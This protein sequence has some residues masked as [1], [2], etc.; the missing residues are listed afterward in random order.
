MVTRCKRHVFI[1]SLGWLL[2]S[3]SAA[4]QVSTFD[5]S[6]AVADGSGAL[7]PGATVTL[8]NTQTG[9]S[10]QATTDA[11]GPYSFFALPVVGQWT[12]RVEIQG[13]PT[14]ERTGLVFQANSKPTISFA[15]TSRPCG[16]ASP[17]KRIRRSSR[18]RR[19]SSA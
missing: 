4:A 9:Q 2:I 12:V 16:K 18:P 15:L 10:R 13:F 14:E 7:L 6:G 11:E 5:L 17:S 3:S 8:Q 1:L 19:R